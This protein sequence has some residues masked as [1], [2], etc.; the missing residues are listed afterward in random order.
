MKAPVKIKC[1]RCGGESERKENFKIRKF[2]NSKRKKEKLPICL[3]CDEELLER[4]RVMLGLS[5]K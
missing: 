3:G 1:I 5:G 2:I 4:F